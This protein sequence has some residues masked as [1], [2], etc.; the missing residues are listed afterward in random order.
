MFPT[1][2][3]KAW[4][5]PIGSPGGDSLLRCY[6]CIYIAYWTIENHTLNARLRR[7]GSKIKPTNL[8][9]PASGKKL[10]WKQIWADRQNRW[11]Y[12]QRKSMAKDQ[13]SCRKAKNLNKNQFLKVIRKGWKRDHFSWGMHVFDIFLCLRR[14]QPFNEIPIIYIMNIITKVWVFN[15]NFHFH[16]FFT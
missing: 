10:V 1:W 9:L 6:R 12:T 14:A 11:L 13:E 16:S 2:C 8:G 3:T 7:N 4:K 15:A 5:S